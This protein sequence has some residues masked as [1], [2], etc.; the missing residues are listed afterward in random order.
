MRTAP[1]DVP[2]SLGS[3]VRTWTVDGGAPPLFV[4]ASGPLADDV[5][6]AL[7]WFGERHDVLEALLTDHGALLLRAFPIDGT[8]AFAALVAHYQPHEF[9]YAGGATPRDRLGPNVY[10][11]TQVPAS[12]DI[13]LHQEMAYLKHYPMKIAFYCHR[14]SATGGE[15]VIGDMRGFMRSLPD[16]FLTELAER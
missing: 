6:A 4:E 13:K 1:Y 12:V 14:K 11:A 10:E 3:D 15:T 9:G 7:T 2:A 16:R 8:E 5:A